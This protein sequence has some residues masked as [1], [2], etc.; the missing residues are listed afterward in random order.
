MKKK[1][2]CF[3]FDDTLVD[4]DYWFKA[5]WKKTFEFHN[6]IF[7][8]SLIKDFFDIYDLKGPYYK[9][10]LQDLSIK[11]KE[12]IFSQEKVTKTF[13]SIEVTES[14]FP[15]ALSVLKKISSN[16][17]FR[18]AIL[19][20]G[21]YGVLINR[22]KSLKI[23]NL[24]DSIV[25]DNYMKKPNLESF[26]KIYKNY[27]DYELIFIGNDHELDFIP[28]NESGFKVFLYIKDKSIVDSRYN[29]FNDYNLFL[30]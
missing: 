25:C 19:S 28:A 17:D 7:T 10:H 24:F 29:Y 30:K 18:L 23:Y 14:L 21:N 16:A 2:F 22:L 8:S 4:E 5:R 1:L 13:K 20:N 9:C 15:G 3:D 12:I 11:H 26:Q 27:D 6:N